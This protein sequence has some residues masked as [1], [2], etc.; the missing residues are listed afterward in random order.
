MLR[1]PSHTCLPRQR[2]FGAEQRREQVEN[3]LLPVCGR[4]DRFKGGPCPIPL[5]LGDPRGS[6]DGLPVSG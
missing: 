4:G 6:G 5:D 2:A 3:C 1:M